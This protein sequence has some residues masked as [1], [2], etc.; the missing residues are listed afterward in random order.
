MNLKSESADVKDEGVE[1]GNGEGSE[2]SL[3]DKKPI[4]KE[5]AG[6]EENQHMEESEVYGKDKLE[7]TS[8]EDRSLK[9]STSKNP[10]HSFFGNHITF[11][12]HIQL[13]LIH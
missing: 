12:L 6:G 7:K 8:V 2:E 13:N 5:R 4:V 9:K 1:N 11:H 10:I 3:Q